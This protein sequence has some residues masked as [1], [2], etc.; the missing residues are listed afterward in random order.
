MAVLPATMRGWEAA[1][2]NPGRARD[3][4]ESRGRAVWLAAAGAAAL[5]LLAVDGI[6]NDAAHLSWLVPGAGTA[7]VPPPAGLASPL[8]FWLSGGVSPS[9]SFCLAALAMAVA[10]VAMVRAAALLGASEVGGLAAVALLVG[11]AW[12]VSGPA[13][14]SGIAAFGGSLPTEGV[15]VALLLL[16]IALMLEGW[17]GAAVAL[18]GVICD[19]QPEV[20]LWGLFGLVGAS[21]ILA[22]EK[23][24]L[25]R[26]WLMGSIGAVILAVPVIVWWLHGGRPL[27]GGAAV[28]GL[29][30]LPPWLPWTVPLANWV[31]CACMLATG[32]A[33]FGVLGPDARAGRGAFLGLLLVFLCGCGVPLVSAD[34][35]WLSLRPVAVESVLQLFSVAAAAA[36]VARDLRGTGGVL[37]V[38]LSVTVAASL[39]LDP[40]L[41]PVAALAMLARAAAAH[42]E[43]LGIERRIRDCDRTML[44]RI[45]LGAIGVAAVAGC[46]L[47][48]GWLPR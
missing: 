11:L 24:P 31:L 6:G 28:D 2:T 25:L 12:P 30:P 19:V 35:G 1:A 26:A 43:L 13:L 37:R 22:R 40:Y 8:A 5:L 14:A 3:A 15:A 48:S 4:V 29:L 46:V 27:P 47:R 45:A 10:C 18:L 41:L 33:A 34:A 16:S 23:T 9:A 17:R 38:A 20:A 42:G 7:S 36:V 21:L 32:L 44:Q 39:L